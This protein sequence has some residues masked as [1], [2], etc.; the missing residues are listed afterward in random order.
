MHVSKKTTNLKSAFC[1]AQK[2]R[3]LLTYLI[4]ISISIS[5]YFVNIVSISYRN[6][7]S[8]IDTA[9]VQNPDVGAN[10]AI[11]SNSELRYLCRNPSTHTYCQMWIR[12]LKAKLA[13]RMRGVTWPGGRGSSETTYLE[14]ATPICLFTIVTFMGL[15]RRLREV[16]TGAPHCKAVFGWKFGSKSRIGPKNGGFSGITGCKC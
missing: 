7:K 11:Y 9:L 3:V 13:M 8:D 12:H 15:Q 14:S 4:S 10:I 2:V 1:H 16:Y 6:W 5:R